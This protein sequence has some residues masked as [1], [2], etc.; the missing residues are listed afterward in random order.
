MCGRYTL[1]IEADDLEKFFS[2][3][4]D[5]SR[6]QP[7]FNIAPSQEVPILRD[8]KHFEYLKWGFVPKWAKEPKDAGWINAR[9]ESITE[10]PAFRSSFKTKRCLVPATGFYE[11][12]VGAGGKMPHYIY[13]KSGKP[14]AMAGVWETWKSKEG[15][16]LETFAILT[17]A[18]NA[19][20]A[21]L[22]DRMPV[23]LDHEDWLPYL[24]ESPETVHELVQ[25][26]L[27]AE[28]SEHEVSKA[29]NSPKTDNSDLIKV[30]S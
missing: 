2:A 23:I 25:R 6:Y 26:P 27:R 3:K 21:P 15:E 18:A 1:N 10:K 4:L 19:F 13:L 16:I 11:W 14:F 7:R 5:K 9:S 20:M 12:T 17:R 22:H 28:L 30:A 29:V 24:N 8:P